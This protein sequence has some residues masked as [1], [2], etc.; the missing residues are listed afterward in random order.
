MAHDLLSNDGINWEPAQRREE[1]N[2]FFA[3]IEQIDTLIEA[4]AEIHIPSPDS[5]E[6][7]GVKPSPL[8]IPDEI[9]ESVPT[10]IPIAEETTPAE[11]PEVNAMD[12]PLLPPIDTVEEAVFN[13]DLLEVPDPS[14]VPAPTATLEVSKPS[15]EEE[16]FSVSADSATQ[17]S[18]RLPETPDFIDPFASFE[19]DEDLVTTESLPVSVGTNSVQD[20]ALNNLDFAA[21]DTFEVPKNKP[22]DTPKEGGFDDAFDDEA[23]L[24]PLPEGQKV[25]SFYSSFD[26]PQ[27]D[28]AFSASWGP[29]NKPKSKKVIIGAVALLSLGAAAATYFL[30]LSPGT[31]QAP[32]QEFST[33]PTP[34]STEVD[35]VVEEVAEVVEEVAEVVE[36]VAEVV[37][38]VAEVV[39]EVAEVAAKI[40]PKTQTTQEIAKAKST[41]KPEKSTS[42]PVPAKEPK[43]IETKKAATPPP[44]KSSAKPLS[45]GEINASIDKAWAAMDIGRFDEAGRVFQSLLASNPTN[46]DANFGYGYVLYQTG[47]SSTGKTYLCNALRYASAGSS[48]HKE[49]KGILKSNRATC[50]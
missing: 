35:E 13:S 49:A 5:F 40:E 47:K 21:Q 37:E 12:A 27:T 42:A 33:Q 7:P 29:T 39:E 23:E 20:D 1:L 24:E 22:A 36:E 41:K 30:N 18:P 8:Q 25:D 31:I 11:D 14:Q 15:E 19:V 2:S 28:P 3:A 9:V 4:T 38:E 43:K 48:T 46:A 17:E 26:V 10:P 50:P 34:I 16:A 32:L 45:S 6:G 44:A